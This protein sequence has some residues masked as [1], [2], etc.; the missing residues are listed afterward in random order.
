MVD[1]S[2]DPPGA[3]LVVGP[4]GRLPWYR[5]GWIFLRTGATAFGGLGTAM[6]LLEREFVEDRRLINAEDLADGLTTTR[7]LPGPTVVQVVAY[8]GFVLGGW[9]SSALAVMAFLAPSVLAM[10]VLS[11]LYGPVAM[12][13]AAIPALGGVA[14]A[15]VGLIAATA[16]RLARTTL[17]GRVAIGLAIAAFTAGVSW[18]AGT[19]VI[20]IVAGLTGIPLLRA[21]GEGLRERGSR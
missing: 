14:A 20:V 11:A 4:Y 10:L 9:P 18:G 3:A 13:P 16:L 6:A 1:V 7:L 8:V 17:R 5:L 12:S 21:S 2:P 15:V 19:L